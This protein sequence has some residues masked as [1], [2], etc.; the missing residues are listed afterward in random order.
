MDE[1]VT[2]KVLPSIAL[3]GRST[4]PQRKQLTTLPFLLTEKYKNAQISSRVAQ[5]YSPFLSV[6]DLL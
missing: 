5:L 1:E 3:Q 6:V 2:H 4:R